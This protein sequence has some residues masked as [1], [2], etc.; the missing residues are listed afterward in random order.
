[1]RN[2]KCPKQLDLCKGKLTLKPMSDTFANTV[3]T[4]DRVLAAQIRSVFDNNLIADLDPAA[5]GA[6]ASDTAGIAG[7]S[8]VSNIVSISQ[9]N[10]DALSPKSATTL[11]VIV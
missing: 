4:V 3:A 8:A 1:M 6:V 11:Y 9:A 2:N 10:Y 5:I 7:A